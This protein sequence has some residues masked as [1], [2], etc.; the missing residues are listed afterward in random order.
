MKR[1]IFDRM[2]DSYEGFHLQDTQIGKGND[3]ISISPK[4]K[5]I[6]GWSLFVLFLVLAYIFVGL[7]F[8]EQP[9]KNNKT[10][11]QEEKEAVLDEDVNVNEEHETIIPYQKD[12]DDVLNAFIDRYFS[13]ITRCDNIALQDMVTD[14]RMYKDDKDLKKKA[15]FITAYNNITVYSKE[16][17]DE[18]SYIVFV[19]ANLDIAGVNS[20]PYDVVTL[21]V[22]NGSRGYMVNNGQLS[23]E[24]QDYIIRIKGDE[25][26]QKIYKMVNKK[27]EEMKE[28]DSTLRDF[29]EIISRR[30]VKTNSVAEDMMT[31]DAS[32][33]NA[34][35]TEIQEQTESNETNQD[36]Q[37]QNT[38]TNEDNQQETVEE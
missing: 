30:D 10:V 34:E 22:V 37:S 3:V 8:G 31:E 38:D 2:S 13:A 9:K 12:A 24:V 29:F 23:Q 35:D 27:N 1:N 6:L 28:N 16:G 4:V 11:S 21:C 19:V 14:P 18:G 15:D 20:S 17:L 26:I 32:S 5:L 36:E 25:D 33:E 7:P